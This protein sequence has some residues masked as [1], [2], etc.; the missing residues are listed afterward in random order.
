MSGA[1]ADPRG[2]EALLSSWSAGLTRREAWVAAR[3]RELARRRTLRTAWWAV[4]L[5]PW[6]AAEL[7][8]AAWVLL[9]ALLGSDLRPSAIVA[10]VVLGGSALAR[11]LGAAT[12][13]PCGRRRRGDRAEAGH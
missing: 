3:E 11:A 4:R 1:D 10:G 6:L 9:A 7:L 13:R 5:A 8:A 2:R 12:P